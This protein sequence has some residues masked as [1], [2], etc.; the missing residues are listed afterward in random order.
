MQERLQKILARAT[1]LSRRSAE[2]AIEKGLVK[3]NG[4]VVTKLGTKADA[5]LDRI[6]YLGKPVRP[7]RQK[8][9][10]VFNKPRNIIVSKKDPEGRETIWDRLHPEMKDVLNSAGRLD[11]DSEGL[12]ILTND[13]DLIYKLTHPSKEVFKTYFVKVKGKVEDEKMAKLRNGIRLEDG[14]TEPARI[15]FLR[16]ADSNA[17]YE[18]SIREGRNRQVRRMFLAVGHAV[19][20][21][22]RTEMGEIRLGT[23]KVGEWRY[24][25]KKE[26]YYIKKILKG[27]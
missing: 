12:L 23:L 19:Q 14:M 3:V 24:L 4:R 9:Y 2:E 8:I 15:N 18:I 6:S 17:C 11:Y 21:L 16:M 25:N 13:G 1:D 26:L 5:E 7:I 27:S 22:R 10:I 20:R